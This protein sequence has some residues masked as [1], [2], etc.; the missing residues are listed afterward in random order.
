MQSMHAIQSPLPTL[1]ARVSIP[2]VRCAY[3][4][5]RARARGGLA[6]IYRRL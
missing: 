4:G 3:A 2:A 6:D 1:L 5:A